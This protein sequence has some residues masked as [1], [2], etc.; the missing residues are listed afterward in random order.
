MASSTALWP[1]N[2]SSDAGLRC[3]GLTRTH[4]PRQLKNM[5]LCPDFANTTAGPDQ[6][7]GSAR[8]LPF[9]I[10]PLFQ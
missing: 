5:E 4:W 9:M 1:S 7:A 2:Y 6:R 10:S 8:A 3:S